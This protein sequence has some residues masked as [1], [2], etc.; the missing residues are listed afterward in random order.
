MCRLVDIGDTFD[1]F[2]GRAFCCVGYRP[3]GKSVI[4]HSITLRIDN[5]RA[6]RDG[7]CD[8]DIG[9]RVE[10]IRTGGTRWR[11]RSHLS[12]GQSGWPRSRNGS[13]KVGF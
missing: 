11:L 12:L 6:S 10:S 2:Q 9:N 13:K 4:T 8:G 7:G 1:A 5:R 3:V